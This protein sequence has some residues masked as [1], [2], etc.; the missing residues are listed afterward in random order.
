M[1]IS[2]NISYNDNCSMVKSK[3]TVGNS[4]TVLKVVLGSQISSQSL[5]EVHIY[6]LQ[7]KSATKCE[8]F[9]SFFSP[10]IFFVFDCFESVSQIAND[11]TLFQVSKTVPW[12]RTWGCCIITVTGKDLLKNSSQMTLTCGSLLPS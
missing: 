1:G 11:F 8:F 6:R 7:P 5:N 9:S 12:T 2:P 4:W 10:H 3:E